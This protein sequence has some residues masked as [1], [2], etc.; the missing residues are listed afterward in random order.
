MSHQQ[1]HV[2]LEMGYNVKIAIWIEENVGENHKLGHVK[3][4]GM[5][6]CVW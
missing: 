3:A 1:Y 5:E 2:C 4:V 6:E